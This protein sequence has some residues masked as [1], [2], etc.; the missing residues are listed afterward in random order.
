M[1]TRNYDSIVWVP[2]YRSKK[3]NI[4][5]REIVAF[6]TETI[7][8]KAWLIADSDGKYIEVKCFDDI[9]K[10]LA[11]DKLRKTLNFFWNIQYDFQA[12]IKYL[13]K[14]KMQLLHLLGKCANN[15]IKIKYIF[16]KYFSIRKGTRTVAFFDLWQFYK[17]SLSHA[18]KTFL[19]DDKRD[20]DRNRLNDPVFV[21][22]NKTDIIDYCIKDAKL[23]KSLA[24]LLYD[25]LAK[26]NIYP[27]HPYSQASVSVQYI[28]LYS[29]MPPFKNMPYQRYAYLS[30]SGGRFELF[31]RGYFD[32][33]YVYDINSAYPFEIYNLI[34][35]T[36]GRWEKSRSLIVD[37]DYGF[38]RCIYSCDNMRYAVVP[39]MF[40]N[41]NV[42][43]GVKNNEIYITL[44]EYKFI[45]DH[46]LGK[47]K[48]LD[49]WFYTAYK[50]KYL[51]RS[52]KKIYEAKNSVKDKD[53]VMYNTYK[54]VLNGLYGKFLQLDPYLTELKDSATDEP[55]IEIPKDGHTKLYL[56]RWKTGNFFCPVYASIITA[57]VRLKLMKMILEHYDTAI[58]TFTDSFIS[59][60]K[61]K[62]KSNKFGQWNYD[63][64]GELLMVGT[65]IYAIRDG[66][67]VVTKNRGFAIDSGT[68]LFTLFER[69]RD[70]KTIKLD[71]KHVLTLG[72][73]LQ[74]K[75]MWSQN[76]L[77]QFIDNFKDIN[78]NMDKKRM[79][80]DEFKNCADILARNMSSATLQV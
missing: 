78:I 3:K 40:K 44:D 51:F 8:G 42:Y 37:A 49:G 48:L 75:R 58:A 56:R 55:V 20:I 76:E 19:H 53:K 26:I 16:K 14:E 77:N 39:F 80:D 47:V 35:I 72:K 66:N 18:S 13:D 17:M 10:F 50:R 2:Q 74:Q 7:D 23:T 34:D 65:G 57:R 70:K 24:E 71:M 54:L 12:L 31:R 22:R 29:R 15:G 38:L 30:Y 67:T 5:P 9:I 79:W 36:E 59:T 28:Q 62:Y 46:H 61:L 33:G 64:H 11:R 21:E 63:K 69:N 52:I 32:E 4:V 41:L 68:D 6:D 60:E 27:T 43:P 45:N 25:K 1:K 73:Y